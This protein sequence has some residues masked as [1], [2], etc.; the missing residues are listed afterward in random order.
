[1]TGFLS[2]RAVLAFEGQDRITF[3]Q[4][5]VSN[6]VTLVSQGHAL[7]SAVLTP[8]GRWLSEFFLYEDTTQETPRLL[9]DCPAEHAETLTKRLSR[10]RLRADVRIVTTDF[11]VI[12]GPDG[13]SPPPHSISSPDPRTEQAGWR[14]LITPDSDIMGETPQAYLIRRLSLGLP[15]WTDFEAEKTLALEANMDVLH[16]VSFSKGCYMGQEL[17]ARTHYRAVLKRRILPI[18]GPSTAFSTPGPIQLNGKDVG[19]LRSHHAT[20]ALALLRREAWSSNA[21]T[22]NG[23]TVQVVWPNWFPAELRPQSTQEETPSP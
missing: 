2:D 10:F 23:E 3:L 22:L 21:L 5:L 1:M 15:D 14:A 20:T 19:E 7:W 16:G 11:R 6:D 4:G 9:M 13:T 18:T 12:T 17:T 8:Q